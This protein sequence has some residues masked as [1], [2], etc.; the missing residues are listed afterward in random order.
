MLI[1]CEKM[2]MPNNFQEKIPQNV[3]P[4]FDKTYNSKRQETVTESAC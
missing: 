3:L 1:D 4:F 2:L